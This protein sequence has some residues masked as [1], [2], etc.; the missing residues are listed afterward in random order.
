MRCVGESSWGSSSAT[1]GEP[2]TCWGGCARS[3]GTCGVRSW[4]RTCAANLRRRLLFPRGA[5]AQQFGGNPGQAPGTITDLTTAA[6]RPTPAHPACCPD[7]HPP[8]PPLPV[9]IRL[10]Q[11][12]DPSGMRSLYTVRL[13][14][15]YENMSVQHLTSTFPFSAMPN[16]RLFA[17]VFSRIEWCYVQHQ[18]GFQR[19]PSEQQQ[20][21]RE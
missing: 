2:V 21:H 12:S 14:V 6:L 9:M 16:L 20:Q 4:S 18:Y 11:T 1:R 19:V 8:P 17:F 5:E 3:G 15:S 10:N 13:S 7:L